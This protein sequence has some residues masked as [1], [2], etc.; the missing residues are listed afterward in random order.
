MKRRLFSNADINKNKS[1]LLQEHQ[2]IQVVMSLPSQRRPCKARKR[3]FPP[4]DAGPLGGS[5]PTGAYLSS[6]LRR[7]TLGFISREKGSW[8]PSG[9]SVQRSPWSGTQCKSCKLIY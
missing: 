7:D 1:V 2:W 9:P 6:V 3:V 5:S 8:Q 4:A